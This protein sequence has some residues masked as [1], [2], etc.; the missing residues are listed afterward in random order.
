MPQVRRLFL[1]YVKRAR[2][3]ENRTESAKELKEL[4]LFNSR[5]VTELLS[6]IKG[7]TPDTSLEVSA[8]EGLVE[9]E[10]DEWGSVQTLVKAR[11]SKEMAKPGQTEIILKDDL[12]ERDRMDLYKTYLLYCIAG[13]V[14]MSPFGLEIAKQRDDSEYVLLNQLGGILGLTTKEVVDVHRRLAEQAFRQ[15]AEVM[16]AD[17]RLTK[18]RIE[19]LNQ[20]QKEVGLP[21]SYAQKVIKSITTTKLA[22]AIETAISQ[23]ELNIKQIRELKVS[24]FD[25]E[26]V[27]TESLRE[28]L[29]KKTVDEIFSSGTGEFDE[30]EVY[31]KI[32]SDLKINV[33]K[34][35]EVV[36]RVARTRISNSLVQAVS[37]LRQRNHQG[38]VRFNFCDVLCVH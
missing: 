21:Q 23:G 28:N 34:A 26:S 33:E 18:G 14:V 5:V 20:L 38:V 8:N 22:G 16:L 13:D 32:P 27:I 4:I 17:G 6:D 9:F 29:F 11:C 12:S 30:E 1:T 24:G 3:A 25:L 7:E 2:A 36:D 19:Q 31:E 37:S 10:D 35:R 15:K